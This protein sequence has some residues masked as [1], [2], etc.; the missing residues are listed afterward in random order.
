[1][2]IRRKIANNSVYY[3]I[4]ESYR[5]NG[6]V[7]KRI[8]IS[9]GPC[10]TVFEAIR[11]TKFQLEIIRKRKSLRRRD[12]KRFEK[13]QRKLELLEDLA[14]KASTLRTYNSDYDETWVFAELTR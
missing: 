3:D 13:L 12:R 5:E 10:P 9:L 7:E 8:I 14:M 4:C 1:M 11:N 6:K 2:F